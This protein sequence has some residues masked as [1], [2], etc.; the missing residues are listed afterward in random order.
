MEPLEGTRV[1]QNGSSDSIHTPSRHL[2]TVAAAVVLLGLLAWQGHHLADWLPQFEQAIAALGPWGPV[3][4]VA[5]VLILSPLLV[6]DSIFGVTAGVVF[7]LGAGFVYYFAAVY[8]ACLVATWASRRLLRSR[9][10]A[11]LAKR[12]ALRGM[13]RAAS[14]RGLR[15]TFWIRLLPLNPPR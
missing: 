15:L 10:L 2:A 14:R 9:A 7:G 13:A 6:P 8:M 11:A 1:G 4:Y 5:A 3:A 12:P